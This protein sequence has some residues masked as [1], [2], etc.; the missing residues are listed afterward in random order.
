MAIWIPAWHYVPIDYNHQLGLLENI[1][2]KCVFTNNTEGDALRLRFNNRY[3]AEPMHIRHVSLAVRNRTTGVCS[4]WQDITLHDSTE[5]V[6][7]GDSAPYS[8][9]VSLDITA[10][11]DVMVNFYFEEKTPLYS[12]VTT[13]TG[14]SWQSSHHVGN[15]HETDSLGFTRQQQLAPTI[16]AEQPPVQFAAGICEI[17][18]L[19][20]EQTKVLA[21]FG[22]SIT[23]M[24]YFSD[25]L[26][27]LIYRRFP[28]K[29]TV[30][31]CGIAGNRL[32]KPYPAA[33]LFPGEGHQFGTAGMDRFEADVYDGITPE[34]VFIMEGVNDCTHSLVFEEADVPSAEDL[35]GALADVVGQAHSH[36]SQVYVS[37]IS[38]FGGFGEKWREP[39]EML[40][41]AYN[42]RIRQSGIADYRVDLDAVL[43]D[44]EDSHRMQQGMHLG[45]GVHPNWAGGRKMADAVFDAMLPELCK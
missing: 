11:D 14:Y 37:T 23:H 40:R 8:D 28:R 9:P 4:Q 7:P 12:V 42:E 6:L 26:A 34:L 3:H 38:P 32:Q 19:A 30:I 31:N 10:Q 36:G 45:D 39:A 29:W 25:Q 16:A 1:T 22:D 17:D 13:A 5:I 27:Q 35:Y 43:R 18:V 15:Y 21:L 33:T 2:Q 41:C 20:R 24:S 44:P